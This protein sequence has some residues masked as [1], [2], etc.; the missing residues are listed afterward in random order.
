MEITAM[1]TWGYILDMPGRPAPELQR[2]AL[3]ILGVTEHIHQDKLEAAK[4]HASAGMTQLVNR[5]VL[6]AAVEPGD[7]VC[8]A[9]TLCLGVSPKDADQFLWKMTDRGVTVIIPTGG[10]VSIKAG[11]PTHE[12]LDEFKRQRQRFATAKSR[13]QA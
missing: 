8:V 4:R 1:K 7:R 5:N 10:L 9:D 12:I 2:E 6:I 3:A 11:D 13:G